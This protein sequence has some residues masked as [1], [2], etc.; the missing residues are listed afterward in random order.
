MHIRLMR[1]RERSPRKQDGELLD[2][3]P[4]RENAHCIELNYKACPQLH[5]SR[6]GICLQSGVHEAERVEHAAPVRVRDAV[7]D[8]LRHQAR[9]GRHESPE[10][11]RVERN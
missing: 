9:V 4:Q 8:L 5:S 10:A 6:C 3:P 7:K 1:A 11:R 2:D